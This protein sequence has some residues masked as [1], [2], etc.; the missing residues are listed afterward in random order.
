MQLTRKFLASK[1]LEVNVIDE[2]IEA[3]TGDVN[4]IK[5]ALDEA[6]KYEAD[7]KKY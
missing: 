1:G 3:H 6:K 4:F 5:D 7:A 2:I